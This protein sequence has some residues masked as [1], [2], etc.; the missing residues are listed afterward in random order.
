LIPD[1][2][3]EAWVTEQ[4][5]AEDA[6]AALAYA[7]CCRLSGE[8]QEAAWADRHAYDA[9]DYH[10]VYQGG[11]NVNTPG[12]EAQVRA[13]PLVQR[14]LARQQAD[15]TDLGSITSDSEGA[16]IARIRI[17]AASDSSKMFEL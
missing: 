11:M 12:T 16:V 13:H 7:L 10:I 8:S 3:A 1:K 9:I 17:R 14:E 6:C 15:L 5:Y 4:A 2:E